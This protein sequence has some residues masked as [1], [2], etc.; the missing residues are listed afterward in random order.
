MTETLLLTIESSEHRKMWKICELKNKLRLRMRRLVKM[1]SFKHP[2]PQPQELKGKLLLL[3]QL[4][5]EDVLQVVPE[6]QEQINL[7]EVEAVEVV[8]VLQKEIGEGMMMKKMSMRDSSVKLGLKEKEELHSMPMRMKTAS[9][10][11]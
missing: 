5:E 11:L 1:L 4:G 9:I 7:V 8:D 6:D 2:K 10:S 3:V